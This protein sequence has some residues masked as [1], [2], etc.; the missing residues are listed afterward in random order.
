MIEMLLV[1]AVV[2]GDCP[3]QAP[4]I[5]PLLPAGYV[6]VAIVKSKTKTLAAAV[7]PVDG[8]ALTGAGC[9][10]TDAGGACDCTAGECTCTS[11]PTRTRTPAAAT[12]IDGHCARATSTTHTKFR[13]VER[14]EKPAKAGKFKLFKR[15]GGC[16]R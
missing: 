12:C 6:P 13:V 5:D 3:P 16:C 7:S 15:R 9:V 1:L 8:V 2:S 4:P 14:F 11:C 10:C